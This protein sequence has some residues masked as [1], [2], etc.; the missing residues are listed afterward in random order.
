[1]NTLENII[2]LFVMFIA[3]ISST[4]GILDGFVNDKIELLI[5]C[6]IGLMSVAFLGGIII[7]QI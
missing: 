7:M 2:V 1:M 6:C 4:I 3:F 5:I